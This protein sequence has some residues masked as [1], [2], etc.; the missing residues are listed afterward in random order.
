LSIQQIESLVAPQI[1]NN[2]NTV[3]KMPENHT[4]NLAPNCIRMNVQQLP[5]ANSIAN[6]PS[7]INN[8]HSYSPNTVL[9][10]QFTSPPPILSVP[11]IVS[12]TSANA[13]SPK[14]FSLQQTQLL[15][16]PAPRPSTVVFSTSLKN[17]QTNDNNTSSAAF[18]SPLISTPAINIPQQQSSNANI[19]QPTSSVS[20]HNTTTVPISVNI[21]SP[22]N[23]HGAPLP[24]FAIPSSFPT[25]ATL[26]PTNV[27]QNGLSQQ[28]INLLQA[29]GV[30]FAYPLQTVHLATNNGGGIITGVGQNTSQ[31][32]NTTCSNLVAKGQL[33]RQPFIIA[34]LPTSLAMQQTRAVNG[35]DVSSN[36]N[37]QK[38]TTKQEN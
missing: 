32:G 11:P 12:K 7:V 26:T 28:L 21:A 5:L 35:F 33:P 37:G 17:D 6:S 14:V 4:N 34:T 8:S 2:M 29:Q 23:H 36:G 27:L 10:P 19:S 30:K 16:I 25:V 22:S 24:R 18:K 38:E 3:Q 13:T 31:P 15:G 20:V 1:L 9:K